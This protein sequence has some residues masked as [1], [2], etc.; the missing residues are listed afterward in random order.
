MPVRPAASRLMKPRIDTAQ[1]CSRKP[2]AARSPASS[3]PFKSAMT[4]CSRGPSAASA[5]RTSTMTP[6]P[7]ASSAAPTL[8]GGES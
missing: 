1:G 8:S 7:S 3:P 4:V 6:T 2:S 5:R